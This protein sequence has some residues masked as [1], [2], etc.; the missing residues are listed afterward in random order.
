MTYLTFFI[1]EKINI[2]KAL[3]FSKSL[4][5]LVALSFSQINIFRR[6][7]SDF[8]MGLKSRQAVFSYTDW[9]KSVKSAVFFFLNKT[10]HSSRD[11]SAGMKS[12]GFFDD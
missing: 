1:L 2:F 4:S 9:L 6:S 12:R 10:L 7:F 5:S 8:W 11:I 3:S